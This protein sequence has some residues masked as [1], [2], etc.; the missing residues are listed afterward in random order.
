MR[1]T[2]ITPG[3]DSVSV[4]NDFSNDYLS[5]YQTRPTASGTGPSYD[6]TYAIA[7]ALAATKGLPVSGANIAA[8]LRRLAGG[9]PDGGTT[10]A[11]TN[12]IK[13]GPTTILAAFQTL[14]SENI[15]GIG[16]FGPLGWDS[17]GTIL[18]GT[19]EMWCVN[20][21][22]ALPVFQSSGLTYDVKTST[23]SGT[24]TPCLP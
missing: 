23:F 14:A 7:F 18:G 12:V 17:K 5:F 4:F 9:T 11:G 19:V 10:D 20:G 3:A 2:G 21:Q 13:L 6:A 1:G 15:T 22:A 8:G 16:T 24:Y